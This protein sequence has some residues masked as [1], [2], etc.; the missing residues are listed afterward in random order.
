M[1]H[2]LR[3]QGPPVL[4]PYRDLLRLVRKE[5]VLAVNASWLFRLAPYVVFACMV[6]AV[7]FVFKEW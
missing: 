1:R 2:L 3:R 4:Q 6:L 5:V 7:F